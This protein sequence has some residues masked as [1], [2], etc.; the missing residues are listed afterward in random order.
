MSGNERESIRV[1][2]SNGTTIEIHSIPD[3]PPLVLGKDFFVGDR[4]PALSVHREAPFEEGPP[5]SMWQIP[6]DLFDPLPE[7]VVDQLGEWSMF[8]PAEDIESGK[9]AI[10]TLIGLDTYDGDPSPLGK[11]IR[12]T[13]H[14]VWGKGYMVTIDCEKPWKHWTFSPMFYEWVVL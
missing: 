9:V 8:R 4:Y 14:D 12:L 10:G 13:P 3:G 11:V 6:E 7:P 1:V 5:L 2:G